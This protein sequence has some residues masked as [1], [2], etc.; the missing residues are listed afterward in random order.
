MHLLGNVGEDESEVRSAYGGGGEENNYIID[1]E[2]IAE[3]SPSRMLHTYLIS[4]CASP[5]TLPHNM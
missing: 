4:L 1:Q 3:A 2:V 5:L